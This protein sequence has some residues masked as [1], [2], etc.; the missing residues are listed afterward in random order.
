MIAGSLYEMT[1]DAD[2]V[3]SAFLHTAYGSPYGNYY[4]APHP[5]PHP[6]AHLQPQ[7]QQQHPVGVL[8]RGAATSQQPS[9]VPTS[10]LVGPHSAAAKAG[11]AKPRGPNT[12]EPYDGSKLEHLQQPSRSVSAIKRLAEAIGD[13]SNSTPGSVG[14][15]GRGI[16]DAA[17]AGAGSS[18]VLASAAAAAGSAGAAGAPPPA[19]PSEFSGLVSYFSS[20]H[21]DLE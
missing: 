20:Q 4:G 1:N 2:R 9:A 7:P 13:S 15:E 18:G 11:A 16:G 10:V 17:A 21:D 12:F 3:Y 6:H 14:E 8:V 5:P 19:Q